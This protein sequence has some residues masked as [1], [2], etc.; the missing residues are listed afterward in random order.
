MGLLL[1]LLRE[2]EAFVTAVDLGGSF[3]YNQITENG[4]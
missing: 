4:L 2:S 1:L 3:M